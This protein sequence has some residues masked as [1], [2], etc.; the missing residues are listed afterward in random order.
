[1]AVQ[2]PSPRSQFGLVQ[3]S[4]VEPSTTIAAYLPSAIGRSPGCRLPN[5]LFL[6]QHGSSI[7]NRESC[8]SQSAGLRSPARSLE[9]LTSQKSQTHEIYFMEY[10]AHRRELERAQ[11]GTEGCQ[12]MQSLSWMVLKVKQSHV[13]VSQLHGLEMFRAGIC[14]KLSEDASSSSLSPSGVKKAGGSL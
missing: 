10:R 7:P 1:M 3:C 11:L 13:E 5:G 2:I 9:C 12:T 14:Q 6:G 4:E 8:H